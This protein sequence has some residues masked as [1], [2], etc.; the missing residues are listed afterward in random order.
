MLFKKVKGACGC[1]L[2]PIYVHPFIDISHTEV[3]PHTLD[4]YNIRKITL[5]W[6]KSRSDQRDRRDGWGSALVNPVKAN[7]GSCLLT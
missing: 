1:P 4:V 6:Q 7:L 3:Y 2:D 5:S